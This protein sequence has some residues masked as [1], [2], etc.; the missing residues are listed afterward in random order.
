MQFGH[1]MLLLCVEKDTVSN[2]DEI[3]EISF[4]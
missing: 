3:S 4:M 1:Y 2:K